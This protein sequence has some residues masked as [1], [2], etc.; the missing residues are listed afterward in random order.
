[1]RHLNDKLETS[2]R[3]ESNYKLL[4]VVSPELEVITSTCQRQSAIVKT[5][6]E[7]VSDKL[8]VRDAYHTATF[9]EWEEQRKD[10]GISLFGSD[11]SLTPTETT[12]E[13]EPDD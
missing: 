12:E 5:S 7:E 4:S 11:T 3:L 1:M 10:W 6:A 2:V 9:Q 8:F 13:K